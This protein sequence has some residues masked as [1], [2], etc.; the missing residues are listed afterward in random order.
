MMSNFLISIKRYNNTIHAKDWNR[1]VSIRY[2]EYIRDEKNHFSILFNQFNPIESGDKWITVDYRPS[3]DP[4]DGWA[5][6]L[7]A[8]D[9]NTTRTQ[10]DS[11]ESRT[12]CCFFTMRALLLSSLLLLC[13]MQLDFRS[14]F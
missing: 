1:H 5:A 14:R 11:G 7:P 12:S 2:S 4:S 6:G 8:L 3:P 10:K 9:N 13:F